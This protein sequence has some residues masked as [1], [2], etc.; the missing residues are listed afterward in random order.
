MITVGDVLPDVQRVL[1]G[2]D[3]T[4]GLSRLND[5]VEILSTE[6]TWDPLRGFLDIV[7]TP[8]ADGSP[9]YVITMPREVG[10][11]LA[12]NLGG[13]PTQGHDF[14]FRFHLNGPGDGCDYRISGFHW[15]DDL[16]VPVYQDPDQTLGN[17]LECT[18]ETAT[19]NNVS[20][21]VY[22]YDLSNAWIRTPDAI[23]GLLVDGFLVP[24]VFGAPARNTNAPYI[25]RI[26]RV[27]LGTHAGKITLNL[28]NADASLTAIG[29][30]FSNDR[31]PQ[32]RR[33]R[34]GMPA[35]TNANQWVRVAFRK[36]VDTLTLDTDLIPLPSKYALV[37]MTKALH[38]LDN[39]RAEEAAKYQL[40]AISY[41]NK[42]QESMEPPG[43]PS[44]QMAD[45]NLIAD[46]HDRIDG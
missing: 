30:Y 12:V 9:N 8:A 34:L 18:L 35:T 38:K 31:E 42:K 1:G 23:S 25:K 16:P 7:A 19:D 33:L 39:D 17:Y 5:A 14:W 28:L 13:H 6:T 44:I 24:T 15:V 40:M 21:R 36:T 22:G 11:V 37:M 27:S 20:V 45:G 4:E 10:S 32:Y 46:K 26:T 29:Q 3:R 43:G 2:V 41:L